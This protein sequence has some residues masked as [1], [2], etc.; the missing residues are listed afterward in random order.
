M[1]EII[2]RVTN[3]KALENAVKRFREKGI[4]LPTFRQ[5]QN[6]ELIPESIKEQLKNIGLW[7]INPLNLFRITWKNEPKE[8][9]G[10]FGKVNYIELPKELTGVNARIILLLGKWFPTGAHKVGAAY[11]CLAPRIITGGFD[12]TTQKAVWPS[13]GNY[14][15]GGAFDSKLMGTES[16]AILPEE[17]S[18]ERFT[19][20]RDYVGSEVIATPG[21]E[22]NVKEIYDK[23]WEIRRTKPD[24][25]IFNQFDEFGNAAWHYNITGKAIEEVF[26]S[27]G[28]K[29]NMAAYV[30]ATGSAGTIAAGDYLRTIAPHIKVVASEAQQC[31][32]LYLNGFGGHRIEGI[33]DK[34]VP[35]IHNVKN[36][37]VI[38]AIDD[39]DC[40]RIFRLF[41]EPEGVKQLINSGV[42]AEIANNLHLLGISGISNMLSA[43]KTAKFFE[44]TS[45][46]VIF[47]IATDSAEMYQSR[48]EELRD[49]RGNYSQIQAAKDFEKCIM[50]AS[51]DWMNELTYYDRKAIHNLKYFT[52]VE[53]QEKEIE[54]L[55]SMWY[56]RELWP[57]LF[58]QIHRWDELIEEFNERVGLLKK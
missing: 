42:P 37:D 25:V 6:P 22:S 35:W 8:K 47:T 17:M 30:S 15:R 40:M 43:I 54:D 9:G 33:G 19:W 39:E 58:G 41:N 29:N 21:C 27:L 32:T 57:K 3:P 1:I 11:G 10:L 56:D 7:E 24:Y 36:T 53:Q 28:G 16:V 18:R 13:T 45:E 12:P 34:H 38:T 52:W 44:L 50:G 2:D 23:C 48:L 20:L 46:D 51:T 5:Q 4:I 14:C 55:N 31:P 26:N 49:E